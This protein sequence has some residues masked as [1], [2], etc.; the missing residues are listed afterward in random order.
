MKFQR[1]GHVTSFSTIYYN[2][3]SKKVL[4]TVIIVKDVPVYDML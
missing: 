2:S 1:F 3:A 4:Y